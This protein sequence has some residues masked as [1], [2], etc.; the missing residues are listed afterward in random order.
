MRCAGGGGLRKAAVLSALPATC[1]L[2]QLPTLSFAQSAPTEQADPTAPVVVGPR[3]AVGTD[4]AGEKA[5]EGIVGGVLGSV[6]GG[7]KKAARSDRPDTRRDPTRKLKYSEIKAMDGAL[8]TAARAQ[9]TEGGLLV[10]VRIDDAPGKGTFQSVFLHTCENAELY[11]G[12]DLIR[13][14]VQAGSPQVRDQAELYP[15]R[16]EIYDLWDEGSFSV[17]WSRGTTRDGQVIDQDSGGLSGTLD[18]GVDHHEFSTGP[19][20]WRQLGFDKAHHGA[21]QI[22]AWFDLSPDELSRFEDARLFVHTTL[23]SQDPVTTAATVWAIES[24]ADGSVV[25]S[26]AVH[27]VHG[28][29]G[30]CHRAIAVAGSSESSIFWDAFPLVGAAYKIPV[31]AQG[32]EVGAPRQA[33]LEEEGRQ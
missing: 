30:K 32:A 19:G 11:P 7:T 3:A 22:G 13:P 5:A 28:W 14:T 20:V 12:R 23:P 2:L 1:L 18:D 21:R 33:E 15:G 10:S 29:W 16:Y 9:W 4:T 6:F 27:D 24:G 8:E 17:G 25:L 26:S 31:R